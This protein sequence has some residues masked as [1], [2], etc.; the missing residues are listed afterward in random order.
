MGGG[1]GICYAAK[2]APPPV[3]DYAKAITQE[4]KYRLEKLKIPAPK[5]VVEPGRSIVG[6]AGVT[7]YSV[8]IIKELKNDDVN[9]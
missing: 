2:D 5:L 7:L 9:I 6:R 8:G 1:W 3:E 4:L